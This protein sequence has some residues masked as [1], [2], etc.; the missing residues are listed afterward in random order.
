MSENAPPYY[1]PAN[2]LA[3]LGGRAPQVGDWFTFCCLDDLH[4]VTAE[5]LPQLQELLDDMP[6][7]GKFWLTREAALAEVDSC[8]E[9][10]KN[11]PSIQ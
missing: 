1:W 10:A 4:Q 8:A 9:I 5:E 6:E 2:V 11:Q 3:M 7:C